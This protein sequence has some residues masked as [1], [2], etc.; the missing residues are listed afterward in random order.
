MRATDDT[1]L[2]RASLFQFLSDDHFEKLRALLHEENYESGDIIVRQ[3]SRRTRFTFF[4][5]A[6]PGW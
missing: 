6:A 5:P 1:L 3:A 4:S 2:R